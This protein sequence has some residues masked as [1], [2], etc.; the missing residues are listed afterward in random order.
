[1]HV[2]GQEPVWKFEEVEEQLGID[3]GSRIDGMQAMRQGR[4]GMIRMRLS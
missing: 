1:M 3:R 2:L 4:F